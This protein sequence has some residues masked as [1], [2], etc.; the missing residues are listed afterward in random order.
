[1][2]WLLNSI[3]RW[4]AGQVAA[5]LNRLWALLSGTVLWVPDVTGLPQVQRLTSTSLAVVDAGFV[6]AIIAAGVTVMT[7]ETLQVRYGVRELAPRLVIAF[8][9]ANLSGPIVRGLISGANALT[10]G[11]TG[12]GIAQSAAFGQLARTVAASLTDPSAA[13]LVAVLGLIIAVLLGMLIVVW[14]VRLALLVCLAGAAP[15]A[16]ACHASPFTDPAARLW[17]RAI[18]GTLATVVLQAFVLHAALVVFFDPHANLPALGLPAGS[19][20]FN[21]FL[22]ACLLWIVVR[23]PGLIRRYVTRGGGHT[24]GGYVLRVLVIQRLTGGLSRALGGRTG[25]GRGRGPSGAARGGWPT[26]PPAGGGGR[27]WWTPGGPPFSAGIDAGRRGMVARA[28]QPVRPYTSGELAA[29]VDLYTRALKRRSAT[30]A[31]AARGAGAAGG[32]GAGGGTR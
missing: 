22:V 31:G 29:G 17:W 10:T 28:G 9:A 8:V 32:A 26:R 30:G 13:L 21:L 4:F 12:D 2:G 23:I 25:A 27:G 3:P 7:R 16:L 24:V 11:L 18:L 5:A 19:G 6:L 14:V 20:T 1:M 15:V